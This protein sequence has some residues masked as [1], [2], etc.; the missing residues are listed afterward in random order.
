MSQSWPLRVT[1][2]DGREVLL[3]ESAWAHIIRL[4]GH[5][6]LESRQSIVLSVVEQPD[7]REGDPRPGRERF[8]RRDVGPSRWLRVIVDFN[9]EPAVIVTAFS[10]RVDPPEWTA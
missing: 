8:W 4:D 9:A 5:P 1:D 6:E 2:P 3:T 10:E 7:H